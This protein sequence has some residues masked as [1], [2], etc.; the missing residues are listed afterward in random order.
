MAEKWIKSRIPD[1]TG[2]SLEEIRN[3]P[4]YAEVAERL[5]EELRDLPDEGVIVCTDPL[6]I[7]NPPG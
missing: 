7:E 2:V 3:D 6:Q 5:V 1:L 4:A